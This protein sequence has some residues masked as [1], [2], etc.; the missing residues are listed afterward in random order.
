MSVAVSA[1][2]VSVTSPQVCFI[3]GEGCISDATTAYVVVAAMAVSMTSS[4]RI[5]VVSR[6]VS[7][8]SP[9]RLLLWV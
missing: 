6:A 2:G 1:N 9:Q 3:G 5:A 8:T 7:A 4:Y